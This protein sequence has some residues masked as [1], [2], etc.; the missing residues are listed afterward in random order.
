[1]VA[2]VVALGLRSGSRGGP[3][4]LERADVRHVL[5]APVDRT[6]AMRGP[7]VR[8]LRFLLFVGSIVGAI[9]G[10]LAAHRLPGSGAEWA[11]CGALFGVS[12]VAL[13]YGTALI[14]SS[15]KLPSWG[16][17]L[18]AVG[19]VAAAI[20]GAVAAGRQAGA[21]FGSM[22]LW[23][24]QFDALGLIQ[25]ALAVGAL[26]LG[27]HLVGD[28]SVEAAER[29]STLVGQLRFAATLQDIR[30]VIVLR[31]QLAMELPRVK[32]WI[33]VRVRGTDRF[34]VWTRGVRGIFRWPAA[35]VARL[36]LLGAVAG[37]AA[38][39][40]WTGTT[41][42]VVVSGLALFIAALDAV[43]PLAQEIDH[44]SRRESV[45]LDDGWV[46][47]RHVPVAVL[48]MLLVAIVGAV[49]GVVVAPSKAAIPIAA[50]CV[51]PAALGAVAGAIV[52]VV[53]GAP[54]AGGGDAWSLLPPEI[55]G[56]RLAFRT[57]WP[58]ALAVLGSV[59]VLAARTAAR[60]NT[61][62]APAAL[63]TG[64][65][66]LVLFVLVCGWLRNRSRIHGWWKAQMELAGR[67]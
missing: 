38:R 6:T 39:G 48:M 54:S 63:S 42:L 53:A 17:S 35:R 4:A 3:L 67:G 16:G 64:I 11:A 65:G 43:E 27:L 22:A 15:V 56:M 18:A 30:T 28:V 55:A 41:P 49:A 33:R 20:L 12:T 13:G 25:I 46:E 44:P 26:A 21:V 61:P 66:V 24:L 60:N 62:A 51:I 34:P 10:V 32:P 14:A 45:P 31:R 8:Q 29:R 37:F 50:A 47:V 5:L 40:A 2:V 59:P 19:L 58:P 57:G 52:S 36:V 7:A 1:M 9:G 23:P